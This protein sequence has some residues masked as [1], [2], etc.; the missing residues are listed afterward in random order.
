M[1]VA[2]PLDEHS[3]ALNDELRFRESVR[4]IQSLN[5]Q[6]ITLLM[7]LG[8]SPNL[9]P[10]CTAAGELGRILREID[11]PTRHKLMYCPF[12]LIDAGFRDPD[13]WSQPRLGT[14]PIEDRESPHLQPCIDLARSTF[15]L[16]WHLV[17]SDVIAAEVFLGISK[18]C[19]SSI[20]LLE[21]QDMQ[22]LA[23]YNYRWIRPRWLERP[24]VWRGLI[25]LAQATPTVPHASVGIRGLQLFL[26]EMFDED[27]TP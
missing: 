21:L 14:P 8:R 4:P 15:V 13:R 10:G 20:R 1:A 11:P 9:P 19:A 24:R 18:E 23:A 3:A 22:D 12:A 6:L 16:A 27:E 25:N 26:G 5:R 2:G 7:D 17:R